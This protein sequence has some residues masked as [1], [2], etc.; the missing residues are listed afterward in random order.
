[1][2]RLMLILALFGALSACS[3]VRT[4]VS[5]FSRMPA[6]GTGRTFAV[7]PLKEQMG[8]LEYQN[9]SGLVAQQL[10]ERGYSWISAPDASD[11]VVFFN[12]SIDQGRTD[13]VD[14]P[15][16]GQTGRGT[17]TYSGHSTGT[18]GGTPYSGSSSGTAY[19]P[20]TFG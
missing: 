8:S 13:H 20:P 10:V 5:R 15:I 11:Y 3:Q 17:T 6:N 19:A 2:H 12:Y 1:M 7:V 16:F 9:Y 4:E 14:L 18:I